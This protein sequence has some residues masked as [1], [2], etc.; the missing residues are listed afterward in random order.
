MN[1]SNYIDLFNPGCVLKV[2][3]SLENDLKDLSRKATTAYTRNKK[4]I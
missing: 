2:I 1:N 4:R 3:W